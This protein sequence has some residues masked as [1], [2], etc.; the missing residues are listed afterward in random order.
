MSNI[1]KKCYSIEK[2]VIILKKIVVIIVI[3]KTVIRFKKMM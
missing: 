1:E 3:K 2:N